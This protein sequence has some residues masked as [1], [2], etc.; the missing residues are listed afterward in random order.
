M[1]YSF[2]DLTLS[3]LSITRLDS[4]RF[5]D[6]VFMSSLE[7]RPLTA[8]QMAGQF[9]GLVLGTTSVA[10]T[11]YQFFTGSIPSA[12]GISYL[13]NSPAN[14][15]DLN[16]GYYLPFNVENRYINF[17]ANLGLVGEGKAGFA[18]TYGAMSFAQAVAAI[19]DKVIGRA[20]AAALGY[21]VDA[22]I[23]DITSRKAYFDA[24]ANER[25]GGFE[26]ELA[27]KAGLAGYVMAEAMKAHVGLYARAAENFYIDLSDGSAD[28]GVNLVGVYGPGSA[29]DGL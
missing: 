29:Y 4:V 28:F 27:V 3:Y 22:A 13:V 19:Y 14:T 9:E 8:R 11:A 10:V 21:D 17:A 5:S 1:S 23:A 12:A 15:S 18:A 26:H 7:N 25:L 16:D 2:A 6:R 24:V 20:Q